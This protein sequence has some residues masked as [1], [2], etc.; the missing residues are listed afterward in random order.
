MSTESAFL[1]CGETYVD[2]SRFSPNM[3]KDKLVTLI[4]RQESEISDTTAYIAEI[5]QTMWSTLPNTILQGRTIMFLLTPATEA[6]TMAV[7]HFDKIF[8]LGIDGLRLADDSVTR[9]RNEYFWNDQIV[10]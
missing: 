7:E 3:H 4:K 5:H 1:S 6:S 8:D 10:F 9:L 2:D